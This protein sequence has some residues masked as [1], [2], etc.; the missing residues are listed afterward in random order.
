MSKDS[1]NENMV[2]KLLLD[3][4]NSTINTGFRT[5]SG[6]LKKIE[7]KDLKKVPILNPP[8]WLLRLVGL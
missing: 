5:Y 6:G 1:S 7:P 3:I 2:F 4:E 8:S